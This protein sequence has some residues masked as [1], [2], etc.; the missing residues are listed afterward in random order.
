MW[1]LDSNSMFNDFKST[2]I[3][4]LL[5]MAQGNQL[6]ELCIYYMLRG[7]DQGPRGLSFE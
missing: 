3:H 5:K 6:L 4:T 7:T 1:E 2:L